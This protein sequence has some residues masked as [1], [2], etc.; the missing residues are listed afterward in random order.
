MKNWK[1]GARISF[2]FAVVILIAAVLGVF[3]YTRVGDIEK[4]TRQVT[5]KSLPKLYLGCVA[6]RN[7]SIVRNL[8]MQFA[9]SSN[10]Q[11]MASLTEQIHTLR[12]TNSEIVA[13][14]EKLVET[15]K[16]RALTAQ[17]MQIRAGFWGAVDDLLSAGVSGS[18]TTK[19]R[20]SEMKAQVR[21][22]GQ[23]YEETAREI[24]EFNKS[25]AD[26]SAVS[27]DASVSS[28]RAGVLVGIGTAILAA[29]LIALFVVR[30][31]TRPLAIAV[32]L[33]DKVAQGD[34]THT[35]EVTSTDEF[36]S[37]LTALNGMVTN[38]RAAVEVATR[39]SEGDLA[40]QAKARSEKDSLG[41]ALIRMLENL[42][43]T[44]EV[45]KRI[46][47]G[48][49][50]VQAKA[51]TDKDILGHAL[52][53]MVEN[54]KVTAEVAGRISQGDLTVQ[55]KALSEK[56][57]LGQSLVRMLESL[58]TTVHDVTAAAA[59]VASGSEEMSST[60]E[61]LS[62][63]AS[64][65]AASAEETTSAMEE[66]AASIQ[67]SADNSRQTDKIASSAAED[68][69]ASGSAVARTVQ[70][71]KEVAEKIN[72]IEEIA[73]KTDLLALNAAVEAARAGEHGKGF[74]VV[75][76]EVRKLAE[77]SQ[78]AAAEISRLTTDGVKTAEDAGQLLAKLVP[79]IRKT[80]E[81][82]REITAAASEQSTGAAQV[83]K[84]I[85]QLDQVIQQNAAAA[86]E[87]ASTSE[88]LSS[89]AQVLQSAIGFF[90][91][92]DAMRGAVTPTVKK[93][94]PAQRKPGIHQSAGSHFHVA[95]DLSNMHRAIKTTGSKIELEPNDG[96]AD[97]RDREF[98]AYHD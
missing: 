27:V 38:L 82:V 68:A 92:D 60:S 16:G 58:R 59:N 95:A 5:A 17:L 28:A 31:I 77:R 6:E 80:A 40:V 10:K 66:M 20:T 13:R 51:R 57:V 79:D 86:E 23:K 56:D 42:N 98:T 3:A 54:L 65:Q 78:T 34:V 30:S 61:Q 83:N 84:A 74:A 97:S 29:L 94:S 48:D 85:Q 91:L 87:M 26:D 64:E 24:V 76:S 7:V 37:M 81:L 89:Q 67:Q 43:I 14:Y 53:R 71:M 72:I 96:S 15:E 62:Q 1:I 55:A 39:I 46:S 45:A 35:A 90:K 9:E 41:H 22:W 69:K 8:A 32:G 25:L 2:G 4:E 12:S 18:D 63:G 44:V 36:G 11:E 52:I 73:R 49:L 19:R 33:V 88:E 21:H 70:A 47:E 75:A 93:T 50:T